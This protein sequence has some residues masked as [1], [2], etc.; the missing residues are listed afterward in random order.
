MT[1]LLVHFDMPEAMRGEAAATAAL[2][3]KI[4]PSSAREMEVPYS[5]SEWHQQ[6]P[7]YE[8]LRSFGCAALAYLS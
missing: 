7:A 2:C 8:K 3:V 6:I 4:T 5:Y 1:F